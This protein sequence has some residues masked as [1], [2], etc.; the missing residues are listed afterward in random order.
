MNVLDFQKCIRYG[1]RFTTIHS[2]MPIVDS[3]KSL[4]QKVDGYCPEC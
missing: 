1:K 4:A 2:M 3:V